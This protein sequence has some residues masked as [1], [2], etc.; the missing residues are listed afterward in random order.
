MAAKTYYVR[1]VTRHKSFL[2][3]G[4][5]AE[6]S[7]W[8]LRL[9]ERTARGGAVYADEGDFYDVGDFR[10]GVQRVRSDEVPPLVEARLGW[11]LSGRPPPPR[12]RA[13]EPLPAEPSR[14]DGDDHQFFGA[15]RC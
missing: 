6:G 11:L 5:L 15:S 13:V 2:T 14:A 7:Y 9:P 8:F 1:L 4:L 12:R 3:G 10:S